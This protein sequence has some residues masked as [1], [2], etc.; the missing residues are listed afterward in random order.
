MTSLL[1]VLVVVET[2]RLVLDVARVFYAHRHD[3]HLSASR[4]V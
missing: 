4:E 2:M 1:F 3:K